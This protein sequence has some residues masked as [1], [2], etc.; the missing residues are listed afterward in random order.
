MA[1]RFVAGGDSGDDYPFQGGLF[2]MRAKDR[3]VFVESLNE[4]AITLENSAMYR[5]LVDLEETV[6]M[7]FDF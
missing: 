2:Q 5:G 1:Q 6:D 7:L 4:Y 3:E